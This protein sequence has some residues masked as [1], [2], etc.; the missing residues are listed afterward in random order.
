MGSNPS[1]AARPRRAVRTLAGL[2]VLAGVLLAVVLTSVPAQAAPGSFLRLA[3]LSPDTPAVDVTVTAF[4]KPDSATTIK[5]VGYGD[6]SGYQQIEPG[7]YT[8]AMRPAGADPASPPVISATLDAMDGRA[9]TVAGL[10][11]FADLALRVL[12]DE[13]GLP[14]PGQARMR[15]VNAA[16]M[17]GDLTIRRD[18]TA[19]IEHAQFGQASSYVLV[20]AGRT[21]LS[22]L[23][24]QATD[25]NLPV[26][27]DAGG[28]YSVLVLER[29]GVLSAQ[30]RQDAKGA[31]VVPA[32]AVETGFGA[33]AST[34]PALSIQLTMLIGAAVAS[35]GLAWM[36]L[37]RRRPV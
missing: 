11:K 19:V 35:G 33:A 17:A 29:N 7:T 18:G 25:T 1:D 12:D 21:V 10:G 37:R 4:S 13:I 34:G 20:P 2:A 15:V 26:T 32:G 30:V 5:G 27:L 23:S 3:H 22:L 9:Y 8:V 31:E 36:L 6:V 14:P 16:P 24:E 28:V